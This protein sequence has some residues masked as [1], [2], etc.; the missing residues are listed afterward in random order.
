MREIYKK[1]LPEFFQ[2]V[3][4][5]DKK[6]ELRKDEDNIQVGD[7]LVL[8]EWNP[9]TKLFTGRLMKKTVTYVLRNVPEYGLMDGYCIIGF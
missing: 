1:I 6:F 9:K 8:E 2:A 7:E 3:W 4:N 5:G